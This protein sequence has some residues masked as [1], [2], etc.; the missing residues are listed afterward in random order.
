[1]PIVTKKVVLK[2]EFRSQRLYFRIIGARPAPRG[3]QCPS[4]QQ[5]DERRGR[6]L[7]SGPPGHS[8]GRTDKEGGCAAGA[9]LTA[10]MASALA[11][12]KLKINTDPFYPG[13]S[14]AEVPEEK[15]D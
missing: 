11:L 15:V 14:R 4:W 10:R 7:N 8:R 12:L 5:G 13:L 3:A 9:C 2:A 1:M 6:S